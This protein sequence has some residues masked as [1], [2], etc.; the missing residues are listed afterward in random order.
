MILVLVQRLDIQPVP[1]RWV[2]F[3]FFR[4]FGRVFCQTPCCGAPTA[5]ALVSL[6]DCFSCRLPLG[7]FCLWQRRLHRRR[8]QTVLAIAFLL[9]LRPPPALLP[10]ARCV[11][12]PGCLRACL[13]SIQFF[14]FPPPWRLRVRCRQVTQDA[15]D[16]SPVGAVAYQPTLDRRWC[17]VLHPSAFQR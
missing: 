16:C 5:P 3:F 12:S 8:F 10:R 14:F 7:F 4:L 15:P 1:F 9:V 13:L 2:L 17:E 11:L 6:R